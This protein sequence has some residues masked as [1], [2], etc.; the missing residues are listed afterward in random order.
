M[1]KVGTRYSNDADG[2]SLL[3]SGY[4]FGARRNGGRF[5]WDGETGCCI[6]EAA[7]AIALPMTMSRA[8]KGWHTMRFR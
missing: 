7:V 8:C 5:F 3:S 4:A 2:V 6:V 1:L